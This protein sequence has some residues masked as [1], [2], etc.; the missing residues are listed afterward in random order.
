MQE[1]TD[2]VMETIQGGLGSTFSAIGSMVGWF[3]PGDS[4]STQVMK[5]RHED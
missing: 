4:Y 1:I 2:T 3:A 5:S